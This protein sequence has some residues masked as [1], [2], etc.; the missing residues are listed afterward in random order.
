MEEAVDCVINLSQQIHGPKISK[1]VINN[2]KIGKLSRSCLMVQGNYTV[3]IL[4]L[5]ICSWG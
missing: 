2:N 3:M 4:P 5:I 1:N